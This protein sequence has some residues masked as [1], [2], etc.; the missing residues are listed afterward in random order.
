L[1]LV[2]EDLFVQFVGFRIVIDDQALKILGALVHNLT[3]A[4]KRGEHARVV[5]PYASAISNVGLAQDKHV[6]NVRAQIGRNTK[7]ILHCDDQHDLPMTPVHKEEAHHDVLGPFVVIEAV[8]QD[9]EGAG[10]NGGAFI[11]F[12]FFFHLFED[13]LLAFEDVFDDGGII[14]VMDKEFRDVGGEET[15][16][17]FG[18]GDDGADGDVLMVEHEVLDEET[19]AGV[20]A[21]DEDDDGPLVFVGPKAD[22]AHVKFREFQIH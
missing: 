9:D 22:G 14:S 15:V 21:A 3:K 10:V 20:T 5:L 1:R 8:V 2:P 13:G 18:A 4:L 12:H 6:I 16:A 7:R 19:L 17:G 11:C